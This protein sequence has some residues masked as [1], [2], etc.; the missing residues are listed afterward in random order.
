MIISKKHKF[1]FIHVPKCA[2]TT[3]S[4]AIHKFYFDSKPTRNIS[5]EEWIIGKNNKSLHNSSE[6]WVAQHTTFRVL[7]EKFD[8]DLSEYYKFAFVRNPFERA[9]SYWK[10]QYKYFKSFNSQIM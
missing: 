7:K 9:V 4:A 2:G 3:I 10:Y 5:E 6:G 1:I 8:E